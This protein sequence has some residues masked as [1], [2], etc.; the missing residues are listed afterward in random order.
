MSTFAIKI[1]AGARKDLHGIHAYISE[2]DSRE[3]AGCVVQNILRV[4]ETLKELPARGVHPPELI[5]LGNRKYRELFLKPYR[6]LY[7][8]REDVVYIALIAD[9]RRD[10]HSLLANRLLMR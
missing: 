10:M 2:N 3:N 9:G 6:I 5:A 1:T 4:I 7:T 8:V